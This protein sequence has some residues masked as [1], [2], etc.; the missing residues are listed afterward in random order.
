MACVPLTAPSVTPMEGPLEDG[1]GHGGVLMFRS[2][3]V[4]RWASALAL[5]G[6]LAIQVATSAPVA[7][8]FDLSKAPAHFKAHISG[9]AE[10]ALGAD[11]I[12]TPRP[13]NYFPSSDECQVN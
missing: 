4:V 1:P 11:Q 6:G 7:S 12:Q 2:I 8:G 3:R 10:L 13:R 5:T 9:P